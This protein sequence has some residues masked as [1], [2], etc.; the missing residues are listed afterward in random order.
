MTAGESHGPELSAI[1][2]GLPSGL[3]IDQV[4]LN[5]QLARRQAG[6]GR[7][8]RQQL[9]RDEGIVTG[10]VRH[11]Q[12][13]GGPVAVTVANRDHSSWDSAMS[14][15][16]TGEVQ[17]NWRDRPSALARPGH[18]DLAGMARGGFAE[19]RPV[20]ERASARE[21][22]ARVACGALAQC[23]LRRLGVEIRAHVRSIGGVA[24]TQPVP[25]SDAPW[26]QLDDSELRCFDADA[27][28]RMKARIDEAQTDRDTLG[29]TIEIVG[30]GLPPG[31]GGYVTSRERLDGRIAGAAMS[32]Q[33]MKGV[34]F[35][36]GMELA[37]LP[38]SHAHDEMHPA[39]AVHDQGMGVA[40]GTNRAGGIEGGMTNGAPLLVRVAMKPLPT[41]MRPLASV[42]LATGL[43]AAAHAERSDTCAVPAAAVVLEAAIA[44]EIAR[45]IREQLG[46]QSMA[47]VVDAWRAYCDRVSFPTGA[48]APARSEGRLSSE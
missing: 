30:W 15:W 20:L 10:G 47:D 12:T 48:E 31:I 11:G 42:D 3:T 7:S 33:A 24:S 45:V 29:G 22:A 41:L 4:F 43:S 36:D 21:T 27:E 37:A 32:V 18:A 2:A 5:A 39:T 14:V 1:V 23:L 34:E 9:E 28:R 19:L 13:M 25:G 6:Y 44:F 8:P 35:G 38:G 16:P 26:S 40:R 17:G 46:M